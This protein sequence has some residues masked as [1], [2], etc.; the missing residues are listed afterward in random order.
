[1]EG[2]KSKSSASFPWWFRDVKP[3][4]SS[5]ETLRTVDCISVELIAEVSVLWSKFNL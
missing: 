2:Q 1:M 4:L 3:K 5:I